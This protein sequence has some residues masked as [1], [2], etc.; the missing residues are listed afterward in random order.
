MEPGLC[1]FAEFDKPNVS[2][3]NDA[4]LRAEI[5]HAIVDNE[6]P[7]S[8]PHGYILKQLVEVIWVSITSAQVGW[9]RGVASSLEG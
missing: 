2:P 4:P 7:V 9:G 5:S 3:G 6:V 1:L 8:F